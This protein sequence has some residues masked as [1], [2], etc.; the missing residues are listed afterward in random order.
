M[1]LCQMLF[2]FS[3]FFQETLLNP[4]Y[5]VYNCICANVDVHNKIIHYLMQLSI[6][7]FSARPLIVEIVD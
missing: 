1:S 4:P 5:D 2:T 3:I 6:N 7:T